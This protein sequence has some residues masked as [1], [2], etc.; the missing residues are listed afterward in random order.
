MIISHKYKFIFIHIQRTGGT[1]IYRSLYPHLGRDDEIYGIM[2]END[3]KSGIKS[4]QLSEQNRNKNYTNLQSPHGPNPWKHTFAKHAREYVGNDIWSKYTTF[5]FIRNPWSMYVSFYYWLNNREMVPKWQG[6]ADLWRH[7]KQSNSFDEYVT[8]TYDN[9]NLEGDPLWGHTLSQYIADDN[10]NIIVD[11]VCKFENIGF[12][13][14]YMCSQLNMPKLF[15]RHRNKGWRA[16]PG[17]EGRKYWPDLYTEK[18]KSLIENLHKDDI[19]RYGY[20]FGTN[21]CNYNQ[22]IL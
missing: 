10:D 4:H 8:N 1:S 2:G 11:H 21:W 6:G 19:I 18:S 15:L 20:E 22:Q 5:A 13:M 9:I 3:P 12:E 17:Q 14:G 16:N 7:I